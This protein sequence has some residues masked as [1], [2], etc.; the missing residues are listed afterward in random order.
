M[1]KLCLILLGIIVACTHNQGMDSAIIVKKQ[2]NTKDESLQFFSIEKDQYN[3]KT[4]IYGPPVWEGQPVSEAMYAGVECYLR[5]CRFK[6][7]NEF[8]DIFIEYNAPEWNF[9]REA[10]DKDGYRF[11]FNLINREDKSKGW[12]EIFSNKGV[13]E[14]FSLK[15][16]ESYLKRHEKDGI[17]FILYGSSPYKPQKI[18]GY[19]IQAFLERISA[20]K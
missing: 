2:L 20:E 15:V 18:P 14:I 3:G 19:Y 5:Y 4:C 13:Q 11:K 6:D 1:K 12:V 9:F 7:G 8:Y 10:V 16:S 17:D